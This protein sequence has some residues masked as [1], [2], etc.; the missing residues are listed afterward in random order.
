MAQAPNLSDAFMEKAVPQAFKAFPQLKLSVLKNANHAILSASDLVLGASGT[1]SLE[2]ALYETPMVIAYKVDWIS[3]M[4][5]KRLIMVPF[6]GLPNL[7]V[8]FEEAPILPERLQGGCTPA[9]LAQDVLDFLDPQSLVS[10]KAKDGLALVKKALGEG[11]SLDDFVEDLL[12][13]DLKD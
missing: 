8:P 5:A 11:I 2:A 9:V 6:I 10:I 4:V 13:Y 3:E 12:S 1:T 7:L